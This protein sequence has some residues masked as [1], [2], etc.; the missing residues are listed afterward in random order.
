MTA[1]VTAELTRENFVNTLAKDPSKLTEQ[2]KELI[3][4]VNA[5]RALGE[6]LGK[7]FGETSTTTPVTAPTLPNAP[8]STEAIATKK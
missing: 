1:P 3:R 5:R 6:D 7:I 2:D 8:T 4:K